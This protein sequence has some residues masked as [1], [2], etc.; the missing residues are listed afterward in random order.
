MIP[1]GTPSGL[2]WGELEDAMRAVNDTMQAKQRGLPVTPETKLRAA[3]AAA[4]LRM[5]AQ[6]YT[7][8][9]EHCAAKADSIEQWAG[10]RIDV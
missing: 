2:T 4:M 6:S 8:V 3:E 1:M 7:D 5:V 9:A 10:L